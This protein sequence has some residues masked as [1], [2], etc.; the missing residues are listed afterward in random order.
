MNAP[1]LFFDRH[2]LFF[3][4]SRG[5]MSRI[6]TMEGRKA[7]I[8]DMI[9][10]LGVPHTEVG[11]ILVNHREVDFSFVPHSNEQIVV[12]A[13]PPPFDITQKTILR[14]HPLDQIL[15]VADVNVGRL[16]RLLLALGFDTV[17]SNGFRDIEVARIAAREQR[18]VLT[19]DT[20]LLK[21]KRIVF[22]RRV[23]E[24]DPYLQ[25]KEVLDFFGLA[26]SEFDFLSRCTTCN[27]RL[28]PV[29][30]QKIL[31]RL[32]PKTKRYYTRFSIC[33][34][35]CRIYWKGSHHGAMKERLRALGISLDS[36]EAGP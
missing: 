24:D 2:F 20:G 21:R 15:F 29:E 6:F 9:E 14:P 16:A 13:I 1:I 3:L 35:C 22:A 30:K 11:A 12:K 10:S 27:R 34:G 36:Q 4:A 28:R 5:H 19:R 25:L 7:S 31:H 23:R 18:V 17:Y 8:K 32:E 33:P 26:G